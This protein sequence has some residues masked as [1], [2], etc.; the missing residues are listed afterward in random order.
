M[1]ETIE[2]AG[3]IVPD[4]LLPNRRRYL[5]Y[6]RS[7]L[8]ALILAAYPHFSWLILRCIPFYLPSIPKF[9]FQLASALLHS[10]RKVVLSVQFLE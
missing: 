3:G 10:A 8:V 6:K 2:L 7:V 1:E 9:K 5:A 4:V